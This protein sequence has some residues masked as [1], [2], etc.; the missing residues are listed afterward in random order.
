[1]RTDEGDAHLHFSVPCPA[2][3][4][5]TRDGPRGPVNA[6]AKHVNLK[7]VRARCACS[8]HVACNMVGSVPVDDGRR[9]GR[10]GAIRTQGQNS[11]FTCHIVT[12]E[13]IF[14]TPVFASNALQ[15]SFKPCSE[16]RRADHQCSAFRT[17]MRTTD[18]FLPWVAFLY[19]KVW[20]G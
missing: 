9:R 5:M 16:I 6:A 20:C 11:T 2:E 17:T 7:G 4:D 8:R 10:E 15:S 3:N 13:L 12:L 18:L 19:L 1:M 14:G